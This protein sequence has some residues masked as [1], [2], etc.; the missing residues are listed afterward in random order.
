MQGFQR[1][2]NSDLTKVGETYEKP[3]FFRHQVGKKIH[4]NEI[5]RCGMWV[6]GVSPI[7]FPSVLIKEIQRQNA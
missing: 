3:A 6:I 5:L 4:K 1:S 7:N 2:T